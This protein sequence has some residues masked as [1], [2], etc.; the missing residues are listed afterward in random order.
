MKKTYFSKILLMCLGKTGDFKGWLP[1][2][3]VQGEKNKK[4]WWPPIY[5]ATHSKNGLLISGMVLEK[6]DF[7]RVTGVKKLPDF[8]Y[9]TI[10]CIFSAYFD[11]QLKLREN[12]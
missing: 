2:Q 4:F 9:L 10:K 12:A 11:F 5:L 8:F 7:S 1:T 3:P 6:N